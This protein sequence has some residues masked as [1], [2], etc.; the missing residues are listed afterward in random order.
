MSSP[1]ADETIEQSPQGTFYKY[2]TL[3]GKG[4]F[5]SVFKGQDVNN[6]N[7]VAWNEVNVRSSSKRDKQRIMFEIQL[8]KCVLFHAGA[9]R[10]AW[11]RRLSAPARA[12]WSAQAPA[13]PL[14]TPSRP[15]RAGRCTTPTSSPTTAAG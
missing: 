2:S 9:A 1:I 12:R 5:K 11:P 6:G 13:L 15:P 4:A 3:L 8:L 7:L 10:C 14:L